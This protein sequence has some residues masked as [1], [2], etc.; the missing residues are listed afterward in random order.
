MKKTAGCGNI[1][2]VILMTKMY[3]IRHCE[4]MGNVKRLFQGATDCDIS[5]VGAIQLGYL[6][7][8]FRNIPLDAVYSSPLIRTRKTAEAVS[9]GKGLEI[10]LH[11]GLIELYGGIVEGKPFAET[12]AAIPGLAETWNLHPQD[13]HPE[14]GESMR[15]AY[16][17][18]YDT[19]CEIARENEG[20]TV[21]AATHGGVIRCL[22]SRLRYGTVERLADVEWCEN[23]DVSLLEFDDDFIP[24]LVFS[25]DHSHVP[26]KYM[27]KRSRIIDFVKEKGAQ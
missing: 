2:S 7:E 22:M 4:A 25:N 8:R 9:D 13:F 5:D 27:P 24:H 17:R 6:K 26:D 23:T 10:K 21:A 1:F 20:K 3:I 11:E 16:E 19:V 12:F 15:H 14:G 18:I